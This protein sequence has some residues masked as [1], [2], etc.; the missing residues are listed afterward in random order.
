MHV[1]WQQFENVPHPAIRT[2]YSTFYILYP[3]FYISHSIS[4]VPHVQYLIIPATFDGV[5]RPTCIPYST[6][7]ISYSVSV[8]PSASC[9]PYPTFHYPCNVQQYSIISLFY[10]LHPIFHSARTYAMF[11][12]SPHRVFHTSYLIFQASYLEFHVSSFMRNSTF[13]ILYLTSHVLISKLPY[14]TGSSP[15]LGH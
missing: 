14:S 10:I 7:R 4:H 13:H 2:K 11:Y 5:P 9:I 15:I 8:P 1:Q 3:T 12:T 6:F